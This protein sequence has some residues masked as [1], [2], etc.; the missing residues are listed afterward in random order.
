MMVAASPFHR[1]EQGVIALN[2]CDARLARVKINC[3][4]Q[5][6]CFL[7]KRRAGT[8]VADATG[9]DERNPDPF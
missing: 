2:R 3:L 9:L 5:F 7:I 1:F 8:T 6:F 4:Y